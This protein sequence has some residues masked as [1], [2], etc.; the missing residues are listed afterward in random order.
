MGH[1]A[2]VKQGALVGTHET[3]LGGGH[4]GGSVH[5]AQQ[6]V[7][8]R[9]DFG[10]VDGAGRGHQQA[11][12]GVGGG[13][14][15]LQ[16]VRVQRRHAGA[17]ALDGQAHGGVQVGGIVQVL[18]QVGRTPQILRCQ[19]SL[20]SSLGNFRAALNRRDTLG[21]GFH[22]LS[23]LILQHGGVV[24]RVLAPRVGLDLAPQGGG[25]LL[26]GSALQ[27]AVGQEGGS[28]VVGRV[29]V[30]AARAHVHA[31]RGQVPCRP[32]LLSGYLNAI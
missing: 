12:G 29:L 11:G 25:R 13:A 19:L 14:E 26:Q 17:G 1:W 18:H 23:N 21:E 6:L 4:F 31:D 20:Y 27:L 8:Q 28:P 9:N 32:S 5:G 15:G 2:G 30:A 22:G 3:G 24:H 16:L 7:T 10:V